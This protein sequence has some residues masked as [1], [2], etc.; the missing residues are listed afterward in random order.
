MAGYA[1]LKLTGSRL[2]RHCRLS[3]VS[4]RST[5]DAMGKE[6]GLIKMGEWEKKGWV[7]KHRSQHVFDDPI[8][9]NA[10]ACYCEEV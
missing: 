6:E 10:F 1:L 2:S 9:G 3:H 4:E 5:K 8:R 7:K